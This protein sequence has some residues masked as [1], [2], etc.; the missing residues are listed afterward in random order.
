MFFVASIFCSEVIGGLQRYIEQSEQKDNV[1]SD[2]KAL[3]YDANNTQNAYHPLYVPVYLG[4]QSLAIAILCLSAFKISFLIEMMTIINIVYLISLVIW[5]PYSMK[6]HN[7]GI[8][9]NQSIIC[10]VCLVQILVKY[11]MIKAIFYDVCLYAVMIL[12]L[13]VLVFQMIRLYVHEKTIKN[14]F[15]L[16]SKDTTNESKD[17]EQP[18]KKIY[19]PYSIENQVLDKKFIQRN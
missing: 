6:V 1:K 10:F 15:S 2:D 3:E 9:I 12:I 5:K 16:K 7:L 13:A 18:K 14:A 8:I 17:I 19:N 4:F 11:Q